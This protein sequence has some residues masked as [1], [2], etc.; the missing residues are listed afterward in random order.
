MS[1]TRHVPLPLAA[2]LISGI[3]L[4]DEPAGPTFEGGITA[5]AQTASDGQVGG[6]AQASL[7]LVGQLPMGPG[8]LTLHVEGSTTLGD[9]GIAALIGEANGDAGSAL[10][11]DDRGRLQ[12]SEFFYSLPLA[13]ATL[14]LGLLDASAGLDTNAV[15]NDE[16][17]QFLAGPL[18]NNPTIGF[19]DYTLGLALDAEP[20]EAGF[21]Y[22]LFLG[23]SH[24]LGDNPERDYNELFSLRTE[25]KGL[26]TAAEGVWKGGGLTGRLGVWLNSGD[27]ERLDG[28]GDVGHNYGFYGALD[29]S[30]GEG[31]WNLRAGWA[32]PEVS[33]A[34]WSLGA[35]LEYPVA[36]LAVTGIGL[37]HTAVSDEAGEGHDD[38]L[39][40]EW[41]LRFDLG[42]HVQL[43][44]LVQY[45]QNPGF[46]GTGDT[47]DEDQWLA[48]LRLHI[49]F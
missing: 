5:T 27:H 14:N 36:G 37:V 21:G 25:G 48:G 40:A 24:G 26:F 30:L 3:S 32:D 45:V 19:P 38:N 20:E 15:A 11:A 10:D 34:A 7:D 29:G 16:N 2:L 4:A 1:I 33:A 46:D 31:A 23:G 41:Y 43:T 47:L 49:A 6:E 44:P 42:E 39:V 8:S 35:A 17:G 9:D 18:V 28:S 22:H 13:G 12:V